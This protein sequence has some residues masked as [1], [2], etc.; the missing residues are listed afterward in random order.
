VAIGLTPIKLSRFNEKTNQERQEQ[1]N[2]YL[3]LPSK[4]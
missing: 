3:P 1:D 2:R 4:Q